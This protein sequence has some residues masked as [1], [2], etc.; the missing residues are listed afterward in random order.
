[1]QRALQPATAPR[2]PDFH[3]HL[4]PGFRP[5]PVAYPMEAKAHTEY[6][7][8]LPGAA[9]FIRSR[10]TY[11]ASCMS[12]AFLETLTLRSFHSGAI[13]NVNG[14]LLDISIPGRPPN[15]PWCPAVLIPP[16]LHSTQPS[17]YS[18]DF[19]W[20]N[21]R[22]PEHT[23]YLLFP[24]TT[25]DA[26]D[27]AAFTLPRPTPVRKK[28]AVSFKT[29]V[30]SSKAPSS[31][32]AIPHVFPPHESDNANTL[33]SEDSDAS[34]PTTEVLSA[35][36]LANEI[37][38]IRHHN[39]DHP[40]DG[41]QDINLTHSLDL[42]VRD[43]PTT[44]M[45]AL[46]ANFPSHAAIQ[47]YIARKEPALQEENIRKA[48]RKLP[49]RLTVTHTSN[50]SYE[51]DVSNDP[52]IKKRQRR[53]RSRLPP[54]TSTTLPLPAAST[55]LW[56]SDDDLPT[57]KRYRV[58]DDDDSAEDLPA[59]A[60]STP[61][62][63]PDSSEP[64]Y[65]PPRPPHDDDDDPDD[66]GPM[67][68]RTASTHPSS[69]ASSHNQSR[70]SSSATEGKK[71]GKS[72]ATSSQRQRSFRALRLYHRSR[73]KHT[74]FSLHL[75]R[76]QV[77]LQ[78]LP[79]TLPTTCILFVTTSKE[80]TIPTR[81]ITLND[82][83]VQDTRQ[84]ELAHGELTSPWSI[85]PLETPQEELET[86]EVGLFKELEDLRDLPYQQQLQEYLDMLP[87]QVTQP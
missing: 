69:T 16:S 52:V 37:E 41:K 44:S 5:D 17:L 84:Q 29:S 45:D 50:V 48:R 14:Y 1:M 35:Q 36:F 86:E 82:E 72:P 79:P 77:L 63:R 59:A 60:P 38:D 57:P 61:H 23:E 8:Y 3:E 40:P 65:L 73:L 49:N 80:P 11:S 27:A 4:Q 7:D 58:L 66:D 24:N 22:T 20:H 75:R 32:Q 83:T 19:R 25:Q 74:R 53:K 34:S 18:S 70:T 85:A 46:R 55:V 56:D 15:Y 9:A 2:N 67:P 26:L 28:P 30:T 81:T 13:P 42:L 12:A 68:P 6:G 78:P 54:T 43:F 33:Y 71:T 87:R 21:V 51:P 76:D 47:R 64:T 62:V 10:G 39:I 31:R